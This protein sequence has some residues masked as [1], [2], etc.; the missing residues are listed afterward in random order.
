MKL[1][2]FEDGGQRRCGA[3]VDGNRVLDFSAASEG[4]IQPPMEDL[5]ASGNALQTARELVARSVEDGDFSGKYCRPLDEVNVLAPI[6]RPGKV[7]C[8]GLNYRDHAAESGSEVPSEPV[9]FCKVS[10]SVIGPREAIRLPEAS[11]KVDYEVELA[12]VIGRRAR[13]V[14]AD[15]A[16]DYVAGYTVLNDVSARD[17]QREKPGGQWTLAKSFDTFCPLGP[18][19]VTADEIDDPGEL[20]LRCV[21]SGDEM[22]SSSTAQMIF[23]IPEIVEYLS[24]VLTLEPGDVVATGTPPGVGF[25]RTPPRFLRSG[26][27][28]ECTVDKVGTLVNPVE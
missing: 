4:R 3:V 6:P 11:E 20:E 19:V 21:V 26:D 5:L 24:R 1:V 7:L 27:V 12:F 15:A 18:W 23:S 2:T 8:L 16:M 14:P 9:V 17:Y 13:R 22:Q 25:A 10:S 28:V